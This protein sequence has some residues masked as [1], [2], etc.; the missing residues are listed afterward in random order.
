MAKSEIYTCDQCGRQKQEANHW[1]L[2]WT[3]RE[4]DTDEWVIS[5]WREGS[6]IAKHLCGQECAVQMLQ[7]WMST[8]GKG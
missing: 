8:T 3:V 5:N 7:E 6:P 1:F 4:F 2:F